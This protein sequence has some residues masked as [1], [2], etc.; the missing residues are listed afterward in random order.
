[1]N[2][3]VRAIQKFEYF[4]PVTNVPQNEADLTQIRR[5]ISEDSRVSDP[6]FNPRFYEVY[7]ETVLFCQLVRRHN[8][9]ELLT[10]TKFKEILD[11]LSDIVNSLI[12]L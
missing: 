11:W 9:H 10:D 6:F 2:G 5:I 1:M 4:Y 7:A 8:H 12:C 3:N